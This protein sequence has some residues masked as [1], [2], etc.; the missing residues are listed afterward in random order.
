VGNNE[1][2]TLIRMMSDIQAPPRNRFTPEYQPYAAGPAAT[3]YAEMEKQGKTY[4]MYPGGPRF[5]W[6][7]E[8]GLTPKK[9]GMGRFEQ[10]RPVLLKHMMQEGPGSEG[11]FGN[12]PDLAA[13][14]TM[15]ADP[16]MSQNVKGRN[17]ISLNAISTNP[18]VTGKWDETKDVASHEYGHGV[19]FV[20]QKAKNWPMYIG[21]H[22]ELAKD[23]ANQ[24]WEEEKKYYRPE[25]EE[26]QKRYYE[27]EFYKHSP[28]EVMSR[29]NQLAQ[30]AGLKTGADPRAYTDVDWVIVQDKDGKLRKQP[31]SGD[32]GKAPY[33]LYVG[34]NPHSNKKPAEHYQPG[35][36]NIKRT[37]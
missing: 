14:T 20:E 32:A 25:D 1:L 29:M 24:R 22:R 18:A 37:K 21:K 23:W 3:N 13:V 10:G 4:E 19:Q 16:T 30:R 34:E 9:E 7:G 8:V 36:I 28:H 15:Q 35:Q 27:R 31:M 6:Q 5:F 17:D 26:L 11:Y 12:Y 33:S 2:E